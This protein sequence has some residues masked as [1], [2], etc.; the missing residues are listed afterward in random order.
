MSLEQENILSINETYDTIDSSMEWV[1]LRHSLLDFNQEDI[2]TIKDKIEN[3][4]YRLFVFSKKEKLARGLEEYFR[5][6]NYTIGEIP[7]SFEKFVINFTLLS[8]MFL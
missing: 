4:Q 2:A 6:F 7:V 8:L 5:D 3:G 1:K